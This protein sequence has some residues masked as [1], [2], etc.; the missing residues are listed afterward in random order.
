MQLINAINSN[1]TKFTPPG[2]KVCITTKLIYP[3]S[4]SENGGSKSTTPSR[5]SDAT[6]NSAA[7]PKNSDRT[8]LE[9]ELSELP[10]DDTVVVRIEVKDTGALPFLFC[11]R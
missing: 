4:Q 11:P 5:D 1:A 2:G 9:I 3:G 10:K 7:S 8:D 6:F